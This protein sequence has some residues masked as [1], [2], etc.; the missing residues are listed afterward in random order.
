MMVPW[1]LAKTPEEA[2][3]LAWAH[4]SKLEMHYRRRANRDRL[5]QLLYLN[6]TLGHSGPYRVALDMLAQAGFSAARLNFT[7]AKLKTLQN[8]VA[9]YPSA[10][11]ANPDGARYEMKERAQLL[12]QFLSGTLKGTSAQLLNQTTFRDGGI[13]GTAAA[14]AVVVGGKP[15]LER[16]RRRELLADGREGRDGHLKSIHHLAPV[17]R[18]ALL[19]QFKGDARAT[20]IIQNLPKAPRNPD[21]DYGIDGAY[22][23][24]NDMVLVCE[25]HAKSCPGEKDGKA[26]IHANGQWL[27]W[28][29]WP[30]ENLP[31]AF[32]LWE[33]RIDDFWS[34]DS[35]VD[36]M[37]PIQWKLNEAVADLQAALYYGS[38]PVLLTRSGTKVNVKDFAKR[39]DIPRVEYDSPTP[40]QIVAFN[41]V[42]QQKIDFIAY[43]ER[44]ADELSG[45]SQLAQSAKNPLG[46]NASGRALEEFD[47]RESERHW[48]LDFNLSLFWKDAGDIL[49]DAAKDAHASQKEGSKYQAMWA[50]GTL[51]RKVPWEDIDMERDCFEIQLEPGN[52]FPETR[53]GKLAS[54]ERLMQAG[55]I[56]GPDIPGLT[57]YP[58]LRDAMAELTASKDAIN[59]W[60]SACSK[61]EVVAFDPTL[62]LDLGERLA[63][64]RYRRAYA[65]TKRG[66][67]PGATAVLSNYRKAIQLVQAAIQKRDEGKALS[68]GAPGLPPGPMPPGVGGPPGDLP[69]LA[70]GDV[71]GLPPGPAPMTLPGQ[72]LPGIA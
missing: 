45:V 54:S 2:A 68:A 47:D 17:P 23:V 36:E 71:G 60:L 52:F 59:E 48:D 28:R 33:Q 3:K 62:D 64:N 24:E 70:P 29:E 66:T 69:G 34:P 13:A 18:Y 56:K 6:R 53:S 32:F 72:A 27:A 21:E 5:N 31:Y 8:R 22:L 1:F 20:G 39:R 26:L 10:I 16:V 38:N 35:F 40:P 44:K 41:P 14:K 67:T 25:S 4:A 43:L 15:G 55:V 12:D 58:D 51:L 30:Y 50:E 7:K 9:K 57:E 46:A 49:V 37:K 61:G 42:A 19:E 63:V 65:E 11:R